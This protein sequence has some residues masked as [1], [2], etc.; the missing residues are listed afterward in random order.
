MTDLVSR[1]LR[2]WSRPGSIQRGHGVTDQVSRHGVTDR[3]S[4]PGSIQRGHGV[5][6]Q[7]SRGLR[8]WSD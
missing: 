5:T 1:G 8:V 3:D 4:R 6:D 7:V 2:A